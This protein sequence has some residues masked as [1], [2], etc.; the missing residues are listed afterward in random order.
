MMDQ[1]QPIT[2]PAPVYTPQSRGV[3]GTGIPSTVAFLVAALLFFMPFIDIKCNN[4]SLQQVSGFQL[5][6]GF[7]MSNNS[8][9][10]LFDDSKSDK[11]DSTTKT[12]T[13]T[14]KK[15][16]NLYAMVGLGLA[17]LGFLLSFVKARAAMGA[18]MLTGILGAAALV[19]MMIDIKNKVKLDMA[20]DSGKSGTDDVTKGLDGFTKDVA[21]KI[22]ISVDFTPWFYISV[23]AFL[24]AA[25]FCV[26]RMRATRSQHL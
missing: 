17:L 5:A 4:V 7:K 2:N 8:N 3:F 13:N 11:T 23:I 21:D 16:P 1:N 26:Q 12:T 19:G 10:S 25:V 6:T 22:N 18:A 9:S 20:N 24:A 14:S 15:D